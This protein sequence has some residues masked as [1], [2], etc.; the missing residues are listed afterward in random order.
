VYRWKTRHFA[1]FV[2]IKFADI[3]ERLYSPALGR[4]FALN[5][6]GHNSHACLIFCADY[7][8][9]A[10]QPVDSSAIHGE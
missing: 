5:T 7:V 10:N 4:S 1:D 8:D 6:K 3:C 9:K 2:G